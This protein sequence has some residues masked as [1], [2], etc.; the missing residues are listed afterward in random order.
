MGPTNKEK[1]RLAPLLGAIAHLTNRIL[2]GAGIIGACHARMVAL[3]M[4]HTLPLYG[5]MPDGKLIST[6]L[7]QGLLCDSEIDQCIWEALEDFDAMFP[8][9]G[10][11]PMQL[12]ASFVDLVSTS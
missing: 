10:H 5:M 9:D 8:V 6:A 1:K 2:Y 11:T 12:D 4:V 3:L 7:A